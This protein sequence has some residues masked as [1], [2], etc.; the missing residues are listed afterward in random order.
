MH[1]TDSTLHST[2]YTPSRALNVYFLDARLSI[3]GL[4]RDTRP[5]SNAGI[6]ALCDSAVT[7]NTHYEIRLKG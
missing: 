7:I 4:L 1:K 3:S 5:I 2:H 6:L